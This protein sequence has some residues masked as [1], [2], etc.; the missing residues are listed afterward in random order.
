MYQELS[1]RQCVFNHSSYTDTFAR[2][3]SWVW[4]TPMVCLKARVEV[5]PLKINI[6]GLQNLLASMKA[7]VYGRDGN[8]GV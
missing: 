4:A 7:V 3:V 6:C 1:L 8:G 5:S 2:L